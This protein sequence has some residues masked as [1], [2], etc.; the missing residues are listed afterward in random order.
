MNSLRRNSITW[1][2][3]FLSSVDLV[4][5]SPRCAPTCL[6]SHR[7]LCA[8]HGFAG[9]EH[10]AATQAVLGEYQSSLEAAAQKTKA[11][12]VESKAA[13]QARLE[14]KRKQMEA[15]TNIAMQKIQEASRR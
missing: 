2:V 1:N 13:L 6:T 7:L 14:Q 11:N 8:V 5:G 15:K 3:S 4:P 10:A 9:D 12:K